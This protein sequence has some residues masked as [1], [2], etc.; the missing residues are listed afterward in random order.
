[1]KLWIFVEKKR[2]FY[3]NLENIDIL[4]VQWIAKLRAKELKKL[5]DRVI[6]LKL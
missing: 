3:A 4:K 5:K 1:M 2:N 6:F